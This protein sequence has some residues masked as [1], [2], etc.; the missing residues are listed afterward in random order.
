MYKVYTKDDSA[1]YWVDSVEKEATGVSFEEDTGDGFTTVFIPW[2]NVSR[3]EEVNE[4][5][6]RSHGLRAV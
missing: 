5:A 1:A 2:Q 4:D 3:I 6:Y